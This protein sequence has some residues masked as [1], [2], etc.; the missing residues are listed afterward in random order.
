[1]VEIPET[2]CDAA[3]VL[4]PSVDRLDRTIGCAGIEVR[5]D[6]GP[7]FPHCPAQLAELLDPGRET[8]PDPAHHLVHPALPDPT[9]GMLIRCDDVLIHP[10]GAVAA[11]VFPLVLIDPQHADAG[12]VGGIGVDQLTGLIQGNLVDQIPPDA[13][14]RR[15]RGNTHPVDGQALEDPAR[16]DRAVSL[17]FGFAHVSCCWKIFTVHAVLVQV[18]RGTRIRNRVGCPTTGRS[19]SC[20]TR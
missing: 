10:V 14:G 17:A 6:L 11:A 13:Q 18:N 5:E 4:E 2:Q 9:V 16:G 1:M 7:A 8:F 3:Q 12:Q 20:R 19:T 15:D